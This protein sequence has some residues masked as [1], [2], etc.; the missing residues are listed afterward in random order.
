MAVACS[1][2]VPEG[3]KV[4]DPESYSKIYLGTAFHGNVNVNLLPGKDTVLNVYANYGG[5]VDLKV[6]VSVT[7]EA[8]PDL[9]EQY[10]ETMHTS[11]IPLPMSNFL[12]EHRTVTIEAGTF[13]SSPMG[14]RITPENL[15]GKGPF[16]LPVTIKG[17][18]GKDYPVNPDLNTLYVVVNYDDSS[19]DYPFY[20]RSGWKILGEE[21]IS[22][23]VLLDGDRHTY[24]SCSQEHDH[25]L[26]VDMKRPMVVHG[27]AFTSQIRLLNGAEYHYAGQPRTIK[28]E[29]SNDN[30][31]WEVV[32]HQGTVPFG[33]ESEIRVSDYVKAR[34]VRLTVSRTWT[35]M[36]HVGTQLSFSEFNV[37]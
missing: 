20:D 15:Q 29:V 6:P 7:F 22:C 13:A 24:W 8:R 11:Y 23:D 37:F 25:T 32:L 4:A 1:K 17:V 26:T 31:N 33:I 21:S 10:N 16:M 36:N 18:S 34:Y 28:V 27:L 35:T 9:V 5:I 12:L 3:F 2:A 19:M 30:E 14:L